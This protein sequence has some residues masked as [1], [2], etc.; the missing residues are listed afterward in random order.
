MDT[1][2]EEIVRLYINLKE[3]RV[4]PI[5]RQLYDMMKILKEEDVVMI[6][7]RYTKTSKVIDVIKKLKF[8]DLRKLT[9]IVTWLT[10]VLELK[11]SSIDLV[12][13][14][15]TGQP[16]FIGIHIEDC[17]WDEWKIL[18]RTVKKQLI[19]EGFD[20]IA[21]RVALV[22]KQALKTRKS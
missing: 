16:Q 20:D 7:Q 21:G 8:L 1:S 10:S 4:I 19:N 2:L 15:E 17:D 12:E 11:V 13:D 22:C 14:L 6:L 3:Q 9:S 18:S 5:I